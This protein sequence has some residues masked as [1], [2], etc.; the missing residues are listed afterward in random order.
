MKFCG[1]SQTQTEDYLKQLPIQIM[2]GFQ[3]YISS[4]KPWRAC[5]ICK[6]VFWLIWKEDRRQIDFLEVGK[7]YL[8]SF[9][10]DGN[11]IYVVHAN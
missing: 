7:N 9:R 11:K 8:S 1:K 3:L 6:I 10:F 2:L 5:T 4:L